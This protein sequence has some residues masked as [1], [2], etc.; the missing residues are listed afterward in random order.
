MREFHYIKPTSSAYKTAWL[1]VEPINANLV[2]EGGGMRGQFTAGVLDFLMDEGVLPKNVVGVSAGALNGLN[3]AAG[4]RGRT[5]HLNTTYCDDWRYLSLRSFVT[6]GDVFGVDYC[7]NQV[8]NKL[9]PFDYEAFARSPLNLVTVATS[10]E[11]G[12]AVYHHLK[13]ARTEID[14]LRASAS[15]PMVSNNV[16]VDG[17]RLLD[18]GVAKSVPVEFVLNGSLARTIGVSKSEIEKTVVVLTQD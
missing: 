11:T 2:L 16:V 6:T 3:Y 10:L 1:D 13:D 12:Q 17:V 5:C 8:P 7:Y 9:D 14:Y 18:G 4:M 15:M